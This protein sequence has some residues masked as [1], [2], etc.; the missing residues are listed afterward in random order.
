[1]ETKSEMLLTPKK[2]TYLKTKEKD[3]HKANALV[4]MMTREQ[5]NRF[6]DSMV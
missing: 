4:Q 3:P 1:M 2:H 6:I 5:P